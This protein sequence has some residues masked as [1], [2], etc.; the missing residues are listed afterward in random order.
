MARRAVRM[1]GG[2]FEL[3]RRLGLLSPLPVWLWPQRLPAPGE[4][5]LMAAMM[6]L[7]AVRRAWSKRFAAP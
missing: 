1:M 7:A 6:R 5:R 2:G 4:V 3:A